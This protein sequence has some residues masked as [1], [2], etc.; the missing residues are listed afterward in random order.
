MPTPVNIAVIG[1][2]GATFAACV[3]RDLCVTKDLNGSHVALMDID[4]HRLDMTHRMGERLSAELRAGLRF[5]A[6]T[7][8]EEALGGADFVLNIA[9]DGGHDWTE[10]QRSLAERH[11]YYRG[12]S[13]NQLGQM[14]FFLD[15]ARD[16]ERICPDAWLIQSGN[17]VFEGCSLMHRAAGVKLIGLCHGHFGYLELA[18]VLGLDRAGVT[19]RT[20]GF[21]HWIWMTDFRYEG[22]DA[23]PILDRWIEEQAEAYW[24]KPAEHFMQNQASRGAIHQYQLYGLMPIGDT[25]RLAGWWYLKDLETR[26]R[27]YGEPWGGFD[28]ELGWKEYLET[29]SRRVAAVEKAAT[30]E[31]RPITE[32]FP[33]QRSAEQIVPIIDSLVNG[34]SATYQVNIPN[35]GPLIPGFPED[36]VVECQAVVDGAGVHGVAEKPFSPRL[37]AGAMIPRWHQAETRI[38]AVRTRDRN[39]LLLHL[40][41]DHRTRSLEQAEALLKDWL[42]EP[43]NKAVADHFDQDRA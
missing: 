33:P 2:G 26:K 14:V 15:V 36:L 39:L 42:A 27:W 16:I 7:D 12:V 6:T 8:R 31:S 17:P 37:M 22:K 9:L 1:A 25:V 21:N 35:R 13:L 20:A 40:L 24:A 3:V 19:A 10:A 29:R 4:E 30:D 32:T 18:D 41:A 23:Y 38:E 28:S 11:G 34:K 43:R 5:S